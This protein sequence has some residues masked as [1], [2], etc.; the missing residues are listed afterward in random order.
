MPWAADAPAV[1]DPAFPPRPEGIWTSPKV[2]CGP[3]R[4]GVDRLFAWDE[5]LLGLPGVVALAGGALELRLGGPGK[6]IAS[7]CPPTRSAGGTART[8]NGSW[9]IAPLPTELAAEVRRLE[10]SRRVRVSCAPAPKPGPFGRASRYAA[11]ALGREAGAVRD[12]EPGGRNRTLNRAAFSLGQ[13]VATGAL[14]RAEVEGALASAAR[15]CGL[16][17]REA[18]ATIRCGLEAGILTPRGPRG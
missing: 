18:A 11:A 7:V 13:I 3:R 17:D 1:H 16:G 4:A 15:D 9:G 12:S 6:Q 5:R 10:R 2:E 14:S 8:W